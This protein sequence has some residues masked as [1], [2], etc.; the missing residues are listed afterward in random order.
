MRRISRI[1]A[2]VLA[3]GLILAACGDDSSSSTDETTAA[4]EET[5][6]A[7]TTAAA[8]EDTAAAE[9]G[10]VDVASLG[11]DHRQPGFDP[12]V[13]SAVERADVDEAEAQAARPARD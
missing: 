3:L 11:A 4:A 10:A 8:T 5:A 6:T 13:E 12:R 1:A 7:D 9:E 2:P